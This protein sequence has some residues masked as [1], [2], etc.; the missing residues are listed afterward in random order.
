MENIII[1]FTLPQCAIN[2]TYLHS[3]LLYPVIQLKPQHTCYEPYNFLTVELW[4]YRRRRTERCGCGQTVDPSDLWRCCCWRPW[5]WDGPVPPFGTSCRCRPGRRWRECPRLKHTDDCHSV[6]LIQ[7]W[8]H[9]PSMWS[10]SYRSCI[11]R[12]FWCDVCSVS[13]YQRITSL[14]FRNVRVW[15]NYSKRTSIL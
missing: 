1:L 8:C 11:N 9:W 4:A 13:P 2:E 5:G 7:L 3:T 6:T 14:S 12:Y 15:C 10:W